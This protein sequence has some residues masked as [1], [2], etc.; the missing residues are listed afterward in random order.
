MPES[1]LGNRY[2][3]FNTVV[4]MSQIE[5]GQSA[6]RL[7][8]TRPQDTPRPISELSRDDKR[9]VAARYPELIP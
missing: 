3:T 8:R 6:L 5:A 9:I 4:R 2:L 7:R 1:L